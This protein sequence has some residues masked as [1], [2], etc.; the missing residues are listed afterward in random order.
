MV[1]LVGKKDIQDRGLQNID[2]V[3]ALKELFPIFTEK[4]NTSFPKNGTCHNHTPQNR[5]RRKMAAQLKETLSV[6]SK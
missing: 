3:L 5:H 1:N 4:G 2:Q 6:I